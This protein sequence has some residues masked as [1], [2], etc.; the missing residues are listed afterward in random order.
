V[1]CHGSGRLRSDGG[2]K[3]CPHCSGKGFT[4]DNPLPVL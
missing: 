4:T 2:L 1:H 3:S